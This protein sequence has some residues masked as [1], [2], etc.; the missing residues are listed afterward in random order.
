MIVR[1]RFSRFGWL[2]AAVFQ[3]LLPAFAAVI[4]AREEAES[5][6]SAS[7][8]HVEAPGS[9]GCPRVHPENCVVCRVLSA[10]ATTTASVAVLAPVERQ[11]GARVEDE[12]R[13]ACLTRFP[14]DPPQRAPPA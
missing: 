6:Q 7:R 2:L 12:N 11:I 14:G 9:S 1:A 3:L 5:M 8:M 10:T 4:D 13:A